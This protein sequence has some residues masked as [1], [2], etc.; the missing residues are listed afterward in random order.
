MS[1]SRNLYSKGMK[2]YIRIQEEN[3]TVKSEW[4]QNEC[5]DVV[6]VERLCR[7]GFDIKTNQ[8]QF[9]YNFK[10]KNQ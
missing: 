1:K 4:S 10:N 5:Y 8:L 2:P 7:Y 9:T 3:S 6:F